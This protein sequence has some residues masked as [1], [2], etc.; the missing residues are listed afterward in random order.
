[1]LLHVTVWGWWRRS[2]PSVCLLAFVPAQ[3]E[4]G[5]WVV[6]DLVSAQVVLSALELFGFC[7]FICLSVERQTSALLGCWLLDSNI[8]LTVYRPEGA[9]RSKEQQMESNHCVTWW[10]ISA[11]QW[12]QSSVCCPW[13][14]LNQCRP[15]HWVSP[16]SPTERSTASWKASFKFD[17]VRHCQSAA[18][19]PHLFGA[20]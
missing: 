15:S 10:R 8:S 5:Q 2:R 11:G 9:W 18:F 7:V 14:W 3:S 16:I 6:R 19:H 12:V 1:M 13:S 4:V 17:F 20:S